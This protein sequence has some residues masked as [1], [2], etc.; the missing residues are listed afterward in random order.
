MYLHQ[1]LTRKIIAA[2]IEVHKNLGPGLLEAVYQLCF[3]MELENHGLTYEKEL[4]IPLLYK[5]RRIDHYLRLDFLVGDAIV[6][7][8]KSIEKMLPVHQAQLLS[9]L[10]L[11]GKQVG[12]LINFN[13]PVLKMGIHRCVLDADEGDQSAA[14]KAVRYTQSESTRR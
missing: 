14:P 6:V 5:H 12:L 11:S 10:R 4:G 1:E 3:S 9:Y 7:E 13:V 2:A 8:L